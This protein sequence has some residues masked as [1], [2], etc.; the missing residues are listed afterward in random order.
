VKIVFGCVDSCYLLAPV[1]FPDLHA[2]RK[3]QSLFPVPKDGVQVRDESTLPG[4]YVF[5]EPGRK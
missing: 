4:M 5:N 2:Y 1:S 3:K